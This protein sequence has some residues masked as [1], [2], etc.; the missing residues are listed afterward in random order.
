MSKTINKFG[1]PSVDI[2]GIKD[3]LIDENDE[4]IKG[5]RQINEVY[6]SQKKRKSCKNCDS[7]IEGIDFYKQNI[8]YSICSVCGHLNG[9][10]QKTLMNSVKL[11]IKVVEK[12]IIKKTT[13][14]LI[15]KSSIK[16]KISLPTQS[17]VF[18]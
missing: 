9:L 18:N 8:P 6:I 5:D 2:A 4:L 3:F 14:R 15:L 17:K 16:E 7:K 1:K 11:L 12:M 10:F 13:W